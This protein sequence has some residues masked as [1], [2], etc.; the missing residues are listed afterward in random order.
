MSQKT[1]R[2]LSRIADICNEIKRP[3]TL[4]MPTWAYLLMGLFIISN[5]LIFIF[6][7][8]WELLGFI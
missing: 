7:L 2:T 8:V 6:D 4:E 3:A 5:I 1:T